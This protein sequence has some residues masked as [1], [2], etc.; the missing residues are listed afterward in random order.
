MK[1]IRIGGIIIIIVLT[2]V[3]LI[4]RTGNGPSIIGENAQPTSQTGIGIGDTAPEL[5]FESPDGEIIALSSLRGTIVLIDFWA[6][7]CGPCRKG[8]P[9]KVAAWHQ[10]RDKEF[11]NGDGFT[12]YSVSLDTSRDAWLKGIEEDKL[13][14][15]N[16]VSDLNGWKSVPAAMYQ[17]QGIPASFLID[18]D[19]V[20]IAKNLR[21]DDIL[22]ALYQFLKK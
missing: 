2:V 1:K 3:W 10:F 13:H 9:S 4:S 16:H 5:E 17:V 12:L 14:W 19:G 15:E 22:E 6:S 18:G 11:V 7:W 21:G 20:I 8:N